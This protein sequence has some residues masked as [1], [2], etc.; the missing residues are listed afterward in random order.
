MASDEIAVSSRQKLSRLCLIL[1]ALAGVFCSPLALCG[2][3]S[4]TPALAPEEKLKA[5]YRIAEG[6]F[7]IGDLI[8][9]A[10]VVESRHE[11]NYQMPEL[12]TGRLG[13]LEIREQSQSTTKRRRGGVQQTVEYML[14]GLGDGVNFPSL[15]TLY[16]QDQRAQSGLMN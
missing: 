4:P 3:L 2:A 8:P 10:L 14:T 13:P 16:Y 15:V 11:I 5:A 6:P 12:P 1:I 9:V 7:A